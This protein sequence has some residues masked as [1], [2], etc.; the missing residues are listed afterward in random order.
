MV[1]LLTSDT[2][3]WSR[4]E[5]QEHCRRLA[6]THYENFTVGSLLIPRKLRQHIY[7]LYGYA[8]T[9]DDLG[10][11]APGSRLQLLDNW[12]RDLDRCYQGQPAHPVM[13]ALQETIN[14]FDIPKEPFWK[15]IQANRADQKTSRY[16]TYQDLLHYC[17]HS[18]NPCGRLVLYVFG[19]RDE[20]RQKLSDFTCTALQLTN[21]WQ[22]VTRDYGMG[23]IYLPLEDLRRFGVTE[24]QIAQGQ[25]DEKFR[26]LMEF[27]VERT[28][29]LFGRGLG[30]VEQVGGI[31]KVDIALF[32]RGGLAVLEAIEKQDYDVLSRRPRL[33]R[34]RKGWLFASTYLRMRLGGHVTV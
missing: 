21:F 23:R 34:F 12:E 10:D 28:K 5:A 1:V 13:V 18:A 14:T 16:Q 26:R 6:L 9:V 27:E 17:D 19:Y 25:A 33:S 24:E 11:E 31:A 22:D 8:R 4:E 2:K 20:A 15:L 30:L 7:N 3:I 29:E 32:N